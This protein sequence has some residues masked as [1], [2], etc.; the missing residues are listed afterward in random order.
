MLFTY[1]IHV[2]LMS[3]GQQQTMTRSYGQCKL[4]SITQLG[5][6]TENTVDCRQHR[7]SLLEIAF[8]V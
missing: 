2:A 3:T 1:A 6:Y 8:A 5:H 4:H 7:G